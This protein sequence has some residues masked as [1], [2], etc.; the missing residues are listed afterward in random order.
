MDSMDLETDLFRFSG[1]ATW[2]YET[3]I[4]SV[5]LP[6]GGADRTYTALFLPHFCNHS[7]TSTNVRR[8]HHHEAK[9]AQATDMMI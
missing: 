3:K 7:T 6:R 9:Q 1:P 8:R 4:D 2:R 5:D